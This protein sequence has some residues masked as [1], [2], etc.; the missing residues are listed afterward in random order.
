MDLK[1]NAS[2]AA[3][4]K[5][6]NQITRVLT[7]DWLA[8]N[9]YCPICGAPVLRHFEANRPAADFYCEHCK[10]EYELKSKERATQGIGDRIADGEYNTR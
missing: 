1:L 5:S 4:Y 9:M 3:R 7:E 10:S 8:R 2:L 6:S